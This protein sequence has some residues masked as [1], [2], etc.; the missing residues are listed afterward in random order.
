MKRW[1]I[2]EKIG[3]SIEEVQHPTIGIPEIE[4]GKT[5]GKK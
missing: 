3:G 5:A 4:N 2:D 1:T